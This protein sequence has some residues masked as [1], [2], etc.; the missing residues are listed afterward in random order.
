VADSVMATPRTVKI[1]PRP[2]TPEAF[3]PFGRVLDQNQFVLHSTHFPFFANITTLRPVHEPITYINRHHDHN[4]IFVTLGGAPMIVIVARKE[5]A[6]E[7]FDPATI[8][9]FESNGQQAI[10]FD[11]DT[12]HIAPRGVGTADVRALNVQATNNR[13]HTERV[14]LAEQGYKISLDR[15]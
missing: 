12:W 2:L 1:R 5:L 3:A 8:E 4:Q 14:E 9:A 10:V 11:V 15:S 7:G 6:G 13:V